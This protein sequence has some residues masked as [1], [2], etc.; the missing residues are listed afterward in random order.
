[1]K[2]ILF[3]T[4]FSHAYLAYPLQLFAKSLKRNGFKFFVTGQ[5][6]RTLES[7]SAVIAT[8]AFFVRRA[9]RGISIHGKVYKTPHD[10]VRAY[11]EFFHRQHLPL[12]FF[13][14]R[15][16]TPSSYFSI[17]PDVDLFLKRQHLKDK[18]IYATRE[19][20]ADPAPWLK[21]PTNKPLATARS[22]QL[23]KIKVAWNIGFEDFGRY[24]KVAKVASWYGLTLKKQ[25]KPPQTPR[26]FLT[27]FRGSFGGSRKSHREAAVRFLKDTDIEGI[28][29]G[30]P[31]RRKQYLCEL[32]KSKAAVSPFGFGEPCYRDFE[33]IL[34]GATLVKPAMDH[35]TTFPNLYDAWETYIPV[36]WDFSDLQ[37]RLLQIHTDSEIRTRIARTAQDRYLEV[38]N[39]PESFLRHITALFTT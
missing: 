21:P 30:P 14:A 29:I 27:T 26:P 22:D 11:A 35:L 28:R 19:Y 15:D 36:Q 12:Y 13:D 17:L 4:T 7:Y 8:N 3:L 31:L 6:P 32:A 1:M 2:K 10:Y 23:G 24:R 9:E 34:Q 5:L 33:A 39:M 20:S 18:S 25:T 37:E 38:L 16:G